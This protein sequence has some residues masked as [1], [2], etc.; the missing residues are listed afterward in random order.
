MTT[1]SP[2]YRI[3]I[4]GNE[5]RHG[6]SCDILSVSITDTSNRADSFVL[7]VGDRH[8]KQGRF[9]G[10]ASLKWMDSEVFDE[11]SEVEIT[12]GYVNNMSLT[13]SGEITAVATQFS[14]SGSPEMTVRGFCHYHRL[15]RKRRTEPFETSTASGIAEEIATDMGFD[16]VVDD[17][18]A[19]H[20]H[21]LNEDETCDAILKAKAEPIG[22]EVTVKE[23]T[24]YFQRPKY[25]ESPGPSLT[26]E[27]GKNL[28]SFSPS[29]STYNMTTEV[30]V[31]ASM[32]SRGGSKT[33]V[34]GTASAGDERVH[35]GDNTGSVIAQKIFGDNP[36]RL[37]HH[38]VAS[39]QEASDIALAK[40]ETGSLEFISA[41]GSCIGMPELKAREV[42]EVKGVGKRYSGTYYVTSAT[43][44]IDAKGYRTTFD[45][46]RNGR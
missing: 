17:T 9:S 41:S 46:K 22:F 21:T 8:E 33:P 27:W 36:E 32:T 6:V 10:G 43:H 12:M 45:V 14:E 20:L 18:E 31:R 25:L 13:F 30:R 11:G 38:D 19:E 37:D 34:V 4:K 3:M 39:Q 2:A 16:A 35:M 23:K 1:Y 42:I 7:K 15:Q 28:S 26:L 5:F 24:L 44:T 29:V 40:L